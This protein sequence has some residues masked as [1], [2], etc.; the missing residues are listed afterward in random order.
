MSNYKEFISYFSAHFNHNNIESVPEDIP[1]YLPDTFTNYKDV[2][3]NVPIDMLDIFNNGT[4]AMQLP[5]CEFLS[6]DK[7]NK[8]IH[9]LDLMR[10]STEIILVYEGNKWRVYCDSARK[11]T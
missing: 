7:K 1:K 9:A 5:I 4:Q 3:S 11:T 8:Y 2:V 6:Y 10:D